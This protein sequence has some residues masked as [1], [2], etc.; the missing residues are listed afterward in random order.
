MKKDAPYRIKVF[1][2]IKLMNRKRAIP[3]PPITLWPMN[4]LPLNQNIMQ[5]CSPQRL[6]IDELDTI[7]K[8]VQKINTDEV[9]NESNWKWGY[10]NQ[11]W[12]TLQKCIGLKQ[13]CINLLFSFLAPFIIIGSK[14]NMEASHNTSSK[15]GFFKSQ[16]GDYF[17]FISKDFSNC[18]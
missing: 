5:K 7:D 6:L 9:R 13:D 3:N 17:F 12:Y 16:L 11:N 14:W 10:S 15:D 8:I 1:W 18:S 4:K 2:W